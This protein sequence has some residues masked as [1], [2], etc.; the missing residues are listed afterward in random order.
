SRRQ[1]QVRCLPVRNGS[2][3]SW[4]LFHRIV[5][6]LFVVVGLG[7]CSRHLI[8]PLGAVL[9]RTLEQPLFFFA[10]FGIWR[11]RRFAGGRFW[12]RDGPA[13]S[14]FLRRLLASRERG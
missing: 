9:S 1:A 12:F 14:R 5:V 8:I 13:A 7:F 10:A 2:R 4:N 3:R 11:R 6:R